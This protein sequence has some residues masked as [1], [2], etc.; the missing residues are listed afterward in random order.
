MEPAAQ[1]RGPGREGWNFGG[2]RGTLAW[3]LL[4][5]GVPAPT[6]GV[7]LGEGSLTGTLSGSHSDPGPAWRY[8][9]RTGPQGGQAP[10]AG[11]LCGPGWSWRR[12]GSRSRL[13][14]QVAGAGLRGALRRQLLAA[15]YAGGPRLLSGEGSGVAGGLAPALAA[16]NP[17]SPPLPTR[18]TSSSEGRC[19]LGG[20]TS[21]RRASLRSRLREPSTQ[22]PGRS[23]RTLLGV[24]FFLF[25]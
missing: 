18:G 21:R 9:A 24:A 17:L 6:K 14:K 22:A 15:S 16:A 10:E 20:G 19:C 8:T 4:V 5:H 11:R 7:S 12:A 23:G 3:F 25:P 13:W 2:P 1:Q